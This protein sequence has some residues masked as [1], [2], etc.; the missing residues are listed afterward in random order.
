MK[1]SKEKWN[2][3]IC[4]V[5]I[6]PHPYII[7]DGCIPVFRQSISHQHVVLP[8][9]SIRHTHHSRAAGC[10]DERGGLDGGQGG[11]EKLRE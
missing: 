8:L 6:I 10:R 2:S 3:K 9:P 1:N 11:V 5:S 7:Q 4:Q